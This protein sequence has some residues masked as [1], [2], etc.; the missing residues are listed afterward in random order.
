MIWPNGNARM[1]RDG[2]AAFGRAVAFFAAALLLAGA[3]SAR[4]ASFIIDPLKVSL[5]EAQASTV[6][7][8]QNT[9]KDTLTLQIQ[10]RSWQQESKADRLEPTRELVATPQIFRIK[11]GATQL[12][13]VALLGKADAQR[14]TAYRLVFDEIPAPPAADFVGVQVAMR[15]TIPLFV[16]PKKTA[17]SGLRVSVKASDNDKLLIVAENQGNAHAHLKKLLFAREGDETAPPVEIETPAYLLAGT[18]REFIV[19]RPQGRLDSLEKLSIKAIGMT[20]AVE[21]D[22]LAQP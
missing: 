17:K 22:G 3:D 10:P 1:S 19:T 6:M 12:V 7:R 18:T 14:E 4:A 15:V 8:V 16:S 13:R 5:N 21:F 2:L 9:G 20:G 11:P